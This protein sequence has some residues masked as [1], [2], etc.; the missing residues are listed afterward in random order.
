MGCLSRKLSERITVVHT[1]QHSEAGGRRVV[2][3]RAAWTSLS[4][5]LSPL[6]S[7]STSVCLSQFFCLKNKYHPAHSNQDKRRILSGA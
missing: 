1:C 7:L 4:S 6:S 5:P 3:L 2:N